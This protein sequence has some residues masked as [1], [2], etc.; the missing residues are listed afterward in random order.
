M[1]A[2]VLLNDV[3][4]IFDATRAVIKINAAGPPVNHSGNVVTITTD[5]GFPYDRSSPPRETSQPSMP[6]IFVALITFL[7]AK[8][9]SY[10][11]STTTSNFSRTPGCLNR[12]II[13]YKTKADE[14]LYK[15]ATRSLYSE[16]EVKFA[17]T[18]EVLIPF[19]GLLTGHAKSCSWEIFDVPIASTGDRKG[20]LDSYGEIDLSNI[21]A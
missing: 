6:T 13:D 21:K 5:Y 7:M 4:P 16:S 15:Q 10:Q 2:Y 14:T 8:L 12:K 19:V 11:A 9:V 3:L 18:I 17:R 20:F 1:K